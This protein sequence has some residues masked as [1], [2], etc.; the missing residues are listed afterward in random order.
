M[1]SEARP[2]PH[3]RKG[4]A[5]PSADAPTEAEP[6]QRLSLTLLRKDGDWSPFGSI[7][8]AI[9]RAGLALASAPQMALPDGAEAS[10]VLGSD[11]LARQLNAAYR[12]KDV[13]TNVLAFPLQRPP[14]VPPE[15]DG[16]LGD[17]VLAAETILREADAQ[18]IEPLD[19]LQHLVVHG[20]LH[21]L[22]YDHD[23]AAAAKAMERLET[24]ILS[25]IGVADPYDATAA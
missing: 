4:P 1:P 14:G 19:H 18:G 12:G 16:Y 2:S 24:A 3:P 15:A 22:G 25:G 23:T 10:I 9:E 20:L 17:I 11:A 7:E 8:A 5:V 21:L 6:P 13:P